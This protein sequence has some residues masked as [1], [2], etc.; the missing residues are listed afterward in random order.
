MNVHKKRKLLYIVILILIVCCMVGGYYAFKP[1]TGIPYSIKKI[2]KFIELPDYEKII[3][4]EG[5]VS[6]KNR[7]NSVWN[8]IVAQTAVK[9]YPRSDLKK[10]KENADDYYRELARNFGYG[11]DIEK[12]LEEKLSTTAEDYESLLENYAKSSLKEQLIVYAIALE[13]NIDLT[14]KEYQKYLDKYLS[15]AG[16]TEEKYEE[17]FGVTIYEYA[18]SK[19][20]KTSILK[21]KVFESIFNN[22]GDSSG[23]S[24]EEK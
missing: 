7:Q 1:V 15:D 12:F 23:E 8:K 22:S 6:D 20:L 4:Q 10:H 21:E 24:T 9:K 2:E 14:E 17:T 18:E 11:D 13:R 3:S 19:N 5:D 16:M